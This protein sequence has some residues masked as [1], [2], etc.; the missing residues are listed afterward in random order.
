MYGIV[1]FPDHTY[2]YLNCKICIPQ[3]LDDLQFCDGLI[4]NKLIF[5]VQKV[6]RL[7]QSSSVQWREIIFC[8]FAYTH[9]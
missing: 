8:I 4:T 6:V 5:E 1:V 9:K 7:K 2:S 3:M